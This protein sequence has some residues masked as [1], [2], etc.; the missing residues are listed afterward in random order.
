MSKLFKSILLLAMLP[1][2]FL[3]CNSVEETQESK[4]GMILVGPK[5]DK[6]WSQAH[7]EGGEY[8][9]SKLGGEMIT[10]DMVNPADSPDL[11]IPSVVEDMI[12]QGA[13]IIFATSDDM[14]DGILEAAEKYPDTDFVWSTGDSAL[15]VGRDY[16]SELKNVSNVMGKM[17]YGQMIAGCAAAI[18]SKTGKIG[19]LGPLVNDETRRLAN[20]T[21]LGAKHCADGDI[22]FDIT[23]IG[24]WFHI[25]GMTLDPTQVVNDFYDSGK[26]VVISHIDTTEAV[27][28]TGQRAEKGEDIWVVPYDYKGA[29]EQ[30]PTR[31]LGVN[32]FNWGP[33][34]LS[35]AQKSR[36]GE[37][38]NEWLW[39]G[40]YW[41][42]L[43]SSIVGWN[44]GE[45]LDAV[46]KGRVG[47]FIEELK[48]GL[49]LFTGPLN[50]N[51]GSV[52]LEDGEIASD[53]DIW[54]T[55]QLLEGMK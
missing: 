39:V 50:F 52:Y 29:C 7:Y 11:T 44:H 1:L 27:V 20:A 16:R 55:P 38:T 17:E 12:S 14:K 32:Y 19:F 31:C 28:V 26:D 35:L 30:A 43:Q 51:D 36:D 46:E 47:N 53:I 41:K 8:A 49:N 40:P 45:G 21:Y 6:G 15:V 42:D 25:P 22:E 33:E 13:T 48:L 10:V 54:Y 9:A 37:F 23:W 18:K 5:N 24:F 4:I 3:G 34:Y 2:L